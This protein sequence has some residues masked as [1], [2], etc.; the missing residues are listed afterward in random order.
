MQGPRSFRGKKI[1][2]IP[3]VRRMAKSQ[4]PSENAEV[5]RRLATLR[6]FVSGENQ[7]AFAHRIGIEVKRWNNFERSHP[8]SKDVAFLL[9]RKVPGLTLDWLFL[10]IEDGLPVKLQRELAEA[11]KATTAKGAR[12]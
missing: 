3:K 6:H 8:L 10:G 5:A 11:G 9:V 2:N 7:T 12:A 1:W 4:N